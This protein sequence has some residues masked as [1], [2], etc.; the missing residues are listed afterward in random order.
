L[1]AYAFASLL[2][3]IWIITKVDKLQRTQTVDT[4]PHS[5]TLLFIEIGSSPSEAFI[6]KSVGG[7]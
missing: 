3:I 5:L 4:D 6:F 2:H 7:Q 1:R